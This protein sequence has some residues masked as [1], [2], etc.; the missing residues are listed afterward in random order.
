MG[1]FEKGLVQLERE[2]NKWREAGKSV[3]RKLGRIEE[4]KRVLEILKKER[5]EWVKPASFSYRNALT[6]LIERI[7]VQF[8]VDK[9]GRPLTRFEALD[10]L[11]EVNALVSEQK[12]GAAMTLIGMD[13]Q[14]FSPEQSLDELWQVFMV[15]FAD[16]A[17]Q[18]GVDLKGSK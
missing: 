14:A 9:S 15:R 13:D 17:R 1:L 2:L 12:F 8:W 3:G 16:L 10:L 5:D 11:A 6:D 7:E 4:R 18:A